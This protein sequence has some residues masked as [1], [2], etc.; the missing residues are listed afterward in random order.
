MKNLI[1]IRHAKSSWK[2]PLKDLDRPLSKRGIGDA[3]L[4]SHA[5]DRFLPKTFI[6]WSSPARRAKETAM[7]YAQNLAI[8]LET[9]MYKEDL[10]TFDESSLENT[11]KNCENKYDNLILFGHNEAI[12]NFV[13]KFGDHY[14]DNVPTSGFVSLKFEEED[15]KNIQ[16]GKIVKTVFPSQLKS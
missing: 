11:I 2:A 13:N 7:I 1:L 8:P 12:T 14:I 10:Y 6:V 3:H 5:V 9:I 16:R 15:W 4:T